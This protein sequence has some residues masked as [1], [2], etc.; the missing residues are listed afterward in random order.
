MS[1]AVDSV[2]PDAS[3][4]PASDTSNDPAVSANA[5]LL[6]RS[7]VPTERSAPVAVRAL[8]RA[9]NVP[10]EKAAPPS[11]IALVLLRLIAKPL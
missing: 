5:P 10:A 9:M 6:P 3:K 11:V 8:P 1:P 7:S 4:M 2:E